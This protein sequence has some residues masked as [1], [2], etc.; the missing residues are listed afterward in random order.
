MYTFYQRGHRGFGGVVNFFPSLLSAYWVLSAYFLENKRMRLLTRVYG[1]GT[2]ILQG[3]VFEQL[4][5]KLYTQ[6]NNTG[7]N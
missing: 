1:I 7:S 4:G 6:E 3:A 5:M 2:T